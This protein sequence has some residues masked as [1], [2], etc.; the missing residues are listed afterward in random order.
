MTIGP[1]SWAFSWVRCLVLARAAGRRHER[2]AHE[3][4]HR[5]TG[6]LGIALLKL[7]MVAPGNPNLVTD[8]A[9]VDTWHHWQQANWH[10]FLEQSYGFVNGIGIA[11]AM[12]LLATR[13][14]PCDNAAPRRRWTE[15]VALLFVVPWLLYENLVKNVADWTA[16]T[17]N[18][19]R[20]RYGC[21]PRCSTASSFRPS[22]G[23]ICSSRRGGRLCH[24]RDRPHAPATG[25]IATSWLGRGQLL[26]FL[27]LWPFVLGNF[28]KALTGF[29][30]QRL[31]TEGVIIVNAAI[32]T[33]L[34]LVLPR[35][36]QA[37]QG[38]ARGT[39]AIGVGIGPVLIANGRGG[40]VTRDDGR[41]PAVRRCPA[42][43][44]STNYRFGPDAN[45][46]SRPILKGTLHR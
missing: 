8:P 17:A 19:G 6:I 18:T 1:A 5:R 45:W 43:H 3:R 2:H 13:L 4:R 27:I 31:L 14:A 46:K 33:V 39:V 36:T 29:T 44:S 12:G 34:I 30:D 42:G 25:D 32:V 28:A 24:P 10:S 20:C 9:V 16:R 23:S 22:T 21:S 7:A 38:M 15:L 41:A 35:K 40:A 37:E 26:Y 11:V